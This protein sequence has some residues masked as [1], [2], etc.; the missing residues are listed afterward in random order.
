MWAVDGHRLWVEDDFQ[1]VTASTDF[2]NTSSTL[3]E[4][5][6]EP[7]ERVDEGNPQQ[8]LYPDIG[9]ELRGYSPV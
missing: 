6:E 2:P 3:M 1:G 5:F 9:D 8:D 7:D 4:P